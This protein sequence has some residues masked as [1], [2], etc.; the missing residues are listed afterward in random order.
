[1]R[2]EWQVA[3]GSSTAHVIDTDRPGGKRSGPKA[4]CGRYPQRLH[5]YWFGLHV[6]E[7]GVKRAISTYS[8]TACPD[9]DGDLADRL[10]ELNQ[11]ATR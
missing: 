4:L 9:C 7:T 1:M 6:A 8:C 3:Q 5:S 2:L 10:A 11:E